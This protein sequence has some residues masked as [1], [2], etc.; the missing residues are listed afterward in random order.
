MARCKDATDK[1]QQ[2]K[3]GQQKNETNKRQPTNKNILPLAT[4][5]TR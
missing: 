5:S 1:R 2:K 4:E 3:K